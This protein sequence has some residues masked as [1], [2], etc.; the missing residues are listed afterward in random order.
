MKKTILSLT[1]ILLF[2]NGAFNL[3]AQVTVGS[4]SIPNATLDV[5][6]ES[7]G[8]ASIAEGIIAPRLTGDQIKAKDG[9]YGILQNGA[10]VYAT[11]AVSGTP[12]GKTINITAAGYYYYDAVD[13]VWKGFGGSCAPNIKVIR[14]DLSA[15]IFTASE[16]SAQQT[17]L[18]HH[19]AVF[20]G[21]MQFP[22]LNS[23][24]DVG[25]V[26]YITNRSTSGTIQIT[27][28]MIDN[29]TGL[30][31][32]ATLPFPIAQHRSRGL[33][34]IGDAWIEITL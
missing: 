30:P 17:V 19:S 12:V 8:N 15:R 29:P 24:T 1:I 22:S 32:T 4:N 13:A 31:Y 28:L 2:A 20:A 11:A 9:V 23:T 10:I 34:W 6:A 14:G 7:P 27:L 5:V 25:K 33:M 26:V 16:F 18:V 3:N 21:N